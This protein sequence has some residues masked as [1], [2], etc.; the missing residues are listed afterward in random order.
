MVKITI[1]LENTALPDSGLEA[2]HGLSLYI[3]TEKY[4]L[5]FDTGPD[6]AFLR[7]AAKLQVDLSRV[8]AV[9]ISHGHYDHTGGLRAF[10]T[11]N[12]HA[13]VYLLQGAQLPFYSLSKGF[14]Y[15]YIG[16]DVSL[17]DEFKDRFHFF[18]HQI[19]PLE[20][21]FL[22]EVTS[23][24]TFRPT[25]N[26]LFVEQNHVNV[27]DSFSHELVMSIA[28]HQELAVFSGCSHQGVVNMVMTIQHHFPHLPVRSLIGGFHLSNTHKNRLTE[29]E[30]VII[31]L[32][33]QIK[34][35]HIPFI[36]TGHCTGQT[37]FDLLHTVLTDPL[38]AMH[39]GLTV[40]V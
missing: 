25:N 2:K 21:L 13:P 5:L 11:V 7:N 18:Q 24:G 4:T 22:T 19:S 16:M 30:E 36:L 32:A 12:H 15:R 9:I 27:L 26:V 1:L 37:G 34:S 8:D 17:L 3:E 31:E 14:P 10:F 20:G 40:D 33:N 39:T 23:Y 6:D 29:K 38:F 28:D 35:L